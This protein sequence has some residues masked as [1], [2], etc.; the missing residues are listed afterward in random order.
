MAKRLNVQTAKSPFADLMKLH[1]APAASAATA[2]EP[3]AA[4]RKRG[5]SADPEFVKL[6]SYIRRQTHLQVKKKLL[7]HGMEISELVEE[8]M[9]RWLAGQSQ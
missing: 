1:E 7:D 4:S 6:T 5:K 9:D 3:I 8:L 2:P